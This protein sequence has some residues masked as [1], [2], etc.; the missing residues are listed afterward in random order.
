[1]QDAQ[2]AAATAAND[3]VNAAEGLLQGY[4]SD[5]QGFAAAASSSAANAASSA[6]AASVSAENAQEAASTAE[7]IKNEIQSIQGVV[8]YLDGHDF[9]D[10]AEDPDWQQTLTD[11]ALAQVPDW[12]SVPNSCDVVNLWDGHEHIYNIE[13]QQWIDWGPATV[14][15]ATNET[16]GTVRGNANTPGKISVGTNGE[17]TVNTIPAQNTILTEALPANSVFTVPAYQ[18]GSGMLK[19]FLYG[20]LCP[21]GTTVENGFYSEVD[22]TTI[23]IFD[24]LPVGATITAVLTA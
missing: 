15:H 3:A 17:M 10:P 19:I 24:S 20:L 4:V 9:G 6:S 22:S 1:V 16:S 23:R 13:T 12:E 14:S 21:A 11:Y 7:A 8:T 5:A 2:E 18:V